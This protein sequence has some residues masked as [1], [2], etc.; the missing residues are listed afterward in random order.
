LLKYALA[1]KITR[2]R[3]GS[4]VFFMKEWLDDFL[5][6]SIKFGRAV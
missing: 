6:E 2:L 4:Y 5:E 3:I 1:G